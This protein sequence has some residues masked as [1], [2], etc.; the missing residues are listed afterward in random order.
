MLQVVVSILVFG[1]LLKTDPLE[2]LN[3]FDAIDETGS[4]WLGLGIYLVAAAAVG[5][6]VT[7]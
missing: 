3:V 1:A 7:P 6:L 2:S 4:F 5:T